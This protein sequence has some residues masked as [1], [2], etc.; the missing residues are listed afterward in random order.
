M[1]LEQTVDMTVDSLG[2]PIQ[3]V[4]PRWSNANA[5]GEFKLQPFG[6][7][8]SEFKDFNGFQ[9]PTRVEAGN[10]F[11]TKEYFPFYRVNV[12]DIR[13]PQ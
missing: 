1:G 11:G 10:F 4:F 6:G 7:Y 2:R 5:Q 8:L 3:V 12:T 9:L 13:F